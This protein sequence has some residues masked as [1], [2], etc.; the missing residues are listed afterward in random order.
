MTE[1]FALADAAGG[2]ERRG[3]VG[4]RVI[5]P[6]LCELLQGGE[7]REA[8]IVRKSRIHLFFGQDETL[9]QAAAERRGRKV[10]EPDLPGSQERVGHGFGRACAGN[11]ADEVA[12]R[13]DIGDIEGR[14]D[15]DAVGQHL[16]DILPALRV[17][18]AGQVGVG[19]LVDQGQ[20]RVTVKNRGDVQLLKV[21][22]PE[23]DRAGGST[24]RSAS[25][26]AVAAR[27]WRSR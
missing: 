19:Q 17:A 7:V 1:V 25:W 5:E 18:L 4:D 24:S 10:D 14:V 21:R 9:G 27:P 26:A 13:F 16:L 11:P 6:E 2:Q 15:V 3:G 23:A 22:P 12:Q 20:P 8:E